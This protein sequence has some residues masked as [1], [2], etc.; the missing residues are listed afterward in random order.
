MSE[1]HVYYGLSAEQRGKKDRLAEKGGELSVVMLGLRCLRDPGGEDRLC[2]FWML[3]C[4]FWLE[5][6]TFG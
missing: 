3:G 2:R 1:N 5:L 6:G 4:S